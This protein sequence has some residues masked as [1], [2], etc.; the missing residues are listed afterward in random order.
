MRRNWQ[1]YGSRGSGEAEASRRILF[2]EKHDVVSFFLG[3][4]RSQVLRMASC[5]AVRPPAASTTQPLLAQSS[6]AA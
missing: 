2:H 5:H 4:R 1:A 6:P 3:D